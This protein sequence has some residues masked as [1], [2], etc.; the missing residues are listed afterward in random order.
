MK[1]L[2]FRIRVYS[3]SRLDSDI[4]SDPTWRFEDMD[5]VNQIGKKDIIP[6]L[7]IDKAGTAVFELNHYGDC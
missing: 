2:P 4:C 7:K 5:V 6:E 1:A 3:R